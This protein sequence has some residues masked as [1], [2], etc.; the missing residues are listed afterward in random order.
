MMGTRRTVFC[1]VVSC[2]LFAATGI[3]L[4]V[5]TRLSVLAVKARSRRGWPALR[6][7]ARSAPSRENRGLARLVLGYREFQANDFSLAIADFRLASKTQSVLADLVNYYEARADAASGRTE[8]GIA[9]LSDFAETYPESIFRFH[10]VTLLAEL[11]VHNNQPERAIAALSDDP[12]TRH[13]SW[14][15]TVLARAYE[16]AGDDSQAGKSY[17]RIYYIF[18]ASSETESAARALERLR[19]RMGP[20]F[21]KVPDTLR[22]RRAAQLL[23]AGQTERALRAYEHFLWSEPGSRQAGEWKLGRARC[24]LRFSQYDRAAEALLQ[25]VPGGA[26]VNAER[27][28]LLIH[29]YERAGDS[30]S[31][32]SSLDELYR[33]YPTS[34]YYAL[35]LLYAGHYFAWRGFWQTAREYYRLIPQSF[36]QS[37]LAPSAAWWTAWYTVLAGND[38][39]AASS[40][41][42]FIQDY[43][44]SPRLPAALYWL[45][46]MKEQEG[47]TLQA[48]QLYEIVV[49]HFPGSYYGMEARERLDPQ[50]RIDSDREGSTRIRSGSSILPGVAFTTLFLPRPAP[51]VL[52]E[53]SDTDSPAPILAAL[54][55]QQLSSLALSETTSSMDPDPAVYLA[56]ARVWAAQDDPA[57]AIFLA[58]RMVPDLEA[59]TFD[60]VPQG[61]WDLLYPDPYWST[62]RTYSRLDH[63]NPYL[64]MGLIR[65]ESA[66]DPRAESSA[67]ARGLMQ[68]MLGTAAGRI[69]SR[70]RRRE[71]SRLLYNPRYN[72]RVSTRFLHTLFTMFGNPEEAVAA[73]NAGDYRVRQWLTNGKFHSPD[74][75]VE[76]I[77]FADT[78][79]YVE[80]VLR[81][82]AIY[83][84]MLGN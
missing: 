49:L 70:W 10:A 42:A 22:T 46:R 66:F 64:V 71:V 40:L 4:P 54:G 37:P 74:E 43:P 29:V 48:Q 60:E 83:D 21:P 47:L 69:R 27:L 16:A 8:Q 11:D 31:M 12:Q 84:R 56:C 1:L 5:S 82:A 38:R 41:A 25:P 26:Q 13:D 77:P 53:F 9:L 52:P 72:I 45:G 50:I 57:D 17:Q 33:E 68:M 2:L 18:P 39:A 28:A 20:S 24:F 14:A 80:S 61:V 73:Y 35:A 63:L 32:L 78:R 30:V 34:P 23:A 36:P 19:V 65:Q 6:R 55:M 7:Y 3:A 15:L 51:F 76:S 59:Y 44:H 67:G 79:V 75:F 81:D 58:K 62:V